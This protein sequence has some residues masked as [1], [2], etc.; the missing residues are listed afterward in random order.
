[1]E[2]QLLKEFKEKM[3]IIDNLKA[4]IKCQREA[5]EDQM[6][7]EL[8]ELSQV[9]G[10]VADMKL[11]LS[12]QALAEFE[13]TGVK[14]MLGG[15]GIRESKGIKYDPKEALSWAKDKD[16]FLILD[17]KAFEKAGAS[18]GLDFIQPTMAATVTFPKEIKLD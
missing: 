1:M 7:V 2:V 17:K 14:K 3:A 18:L 10:D 8:N 11:V 12:K 16:M 4:S 13:E 5:L 9:L 6:S 15:I